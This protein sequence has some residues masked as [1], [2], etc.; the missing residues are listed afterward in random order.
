MKNQAASVYDRLR[1]RMSAEDVI[2]RLGLHVVRRSGNEVHL[3]PLCHASD[4]GSSLHLNLDTGRWLCFACQTM[5]VSGDLFQFVEYVLSGGQ[6]PMKGS[7]AMNR[8]QHIEAIRWLCEQYVVP[9][10]MDRMRPPAE[11]EALDHFAGLAHDYLLSGEADDV[12]E[13]IDKQWGFSR[14][15]VESFRIGFMPAPVIPDLISAIEGSADLRNAFRSC[16]VGFVHSKTGNFVTPFEGRV[17][18]PYLE[19]GR[20]VYLIG[21]STPWTPKHEGRAAKY[22]KLPV[23]SETRPYISPRINNA[24]LFNDGSLAGARRVIVTEGVADA[25]ALAS[26]GVQG[27]VSPVGLSAREDV[28][29]ALADRM[30]SEGAEHIDIAY[31]SELSGSGSQGARA[32]AL[33]M[34]ERGLS[35]SILSF[36]RGPA[37]ERAFAEVVGIIGE[38]KLVVLESLERA[39]ER[40][41]FLEEAVP[42]PNKREWFLSQVSASKVDGAE[43][44]SFHGSGAKGEFDQLRMDAEDYPVQLARE[45]ANKSDLFSMLEEDRLRLMAEPIRL[46]ACCDSNIK[47]GK[48]AK[49]IAGLSGKGITKAIV[50]KE[51]SRFRRERKEALKEQSVE[52]RTH[53]PA[54]TNELHVP[55]PRLEHTTPAAPEAPAADP[56]DTR[57]AAPSSPATKTQQSSEFEHFSTM[58]GT[59]ERIVKKKEPEDPVGHAIAQAIVGS[60]GFTV[61]LANDGMFLV[62]SSERVPAHPRSESFGHVL[63]TV[64]GLMPAKPA[65]RGYIEAT[66]FHLRRVAKRVRDVSW[67][68]VVPGERAV[69]FPTGERGHLLLVE[70]GLVSRTTMAEAKVP[71]VAG[72]D[73]Q[74]FKYTPGVTDGISKATSLFR[75]A[76]LSKGDRMILL[77]WVA[78]LPILRLVGTVPIVRIEGG[79]SSGKTRTVDGVSWL[80]NGCES[81]CVP[82]AAALIS[83]LST[84]ML[85]ID[86]NRESRDVTPAFQGTLLQATH[87]GARE[88]RKVNSDTGTIVERVAGALLMNGIE[89]IHDGKSELASRILTLRADASHRFPDSPTDNE[90]FYRELGKIRDSFW[91]EAIERCATAL[92]LDRDFGEAVGLEIE[93]IFGATKIGRLSAFLRLMYFVWIAGE[94]E[95]MWDSLIH[96]VSPI[97]RQAFE[98]MGGHVLESLIKEDLVSQAIR[99]V[100]AFG[101]FQSAKP[102]PSANRSEA[103][104]GDYAAADDGSWQTIGPVTS[105]RLAQLVRMAGRELNAPDAVTRSLRAGQLEARILDG[106]DVLASAGIKA[107]WDATGRRIVWTFTREE[108]RPMTN[109]ATEFIEGAAG[110]LPTAPPPLAPPPPPAL[111]PSPAAPGGLY[112][113]LDQALGDPE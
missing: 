63:Y 27:V 112:G 8:P 74:P 77:H 21:R 85:T 93:G 95:E 9:F 82:T 20:A 41:A 60:M 51:V 34:V 59:I 40:K 3:E 28:A 98:S 97:W 91:S 47:R 32:T 79:S 53:E 110:G 4:S 6:A 96:R 67:S 113:D 17:T 64:A 88:K 94:P 2:R 7:G 90:T 75:W 45:I 35:V 68:Y 18:F 52:E 48:Y 12:L 111:G 61:F 104:G 108:V 23:H 25:V 31:D 24:H 5:G 33:R 89:P 81:S 101:E 30:R 19:H 22:Y 1:E 83:R 66:L 38:E 78:T 71:A 80:V 87:L 13:W 29:D 102:F 84:S 16:G 46:A 100:F 37:Q 56:N 42:E 70:P 15:V 36:S 103:F 58:R 107:S 76:S 43:W 106:L 11:M 92:E 86:D 44:V 39:V 50:E 109:Q 65:H 49:A 69:F 57:P 99:Y 26:V 105:D 10:E 72:A 55:P 62:R 73:F 14:D 54:A